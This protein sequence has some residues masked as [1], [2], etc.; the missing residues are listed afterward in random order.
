MPDLLP[1]QPQYRFQSINLRSVDFPD[2]FHH[3]LHDGPIEEKVLENIRTFGQVHPL[4]VHEQPNG[5]FHLLGGYTDFAACKALDLKSVV[6]QVLPFS[7]PAVTLCAVRILHDLSSSRTN[8]ILQAS[9][10]RQMQHDLTREEQLPLL[11]LLGYAPE[12]RKLKDIIALLDLDSMAVLALHRGLL[13]PKTAKQLALHAREDQRHMVELI[14]THRLGGSKQQKLVELLTELALRNHR[15]AQDF[16]EEWRT[17][18]Q[19]AT[20]DNMPQQMQDLMAYLFAENAPASTQAK[21]RFQ[22][23]VRQLRPP[24]G[25]IIDHSLSFEDERVVVRLDFANKE[26]LL[27]KWEQLKEVMTGPDDVV[28]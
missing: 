4:P 3:F 5:H 27:E 8:P 10:L 17:H 6:G 26:A 18:R 1:E 25:I 13:S 16:I 9:I 21:D 24:A 14:A 2:N 23:M 7:T 19:P 20:A 12:S 15:P 11:A 22:K 28:L